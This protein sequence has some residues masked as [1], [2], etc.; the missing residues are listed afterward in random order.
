MEEEVQKTNV[1]PKNVKLKKEGGQKKRGLYDFK[2]KKKVY[3]L[4]LKQGKIK[5]KKS[6]LEELEQVW[7]VMVF[8]S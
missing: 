5:K 3:L 1:K 2:M 4:V 6:C 8:E 7:V